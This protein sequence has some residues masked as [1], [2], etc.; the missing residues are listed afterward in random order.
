M[1]INH[2]NALIYGCMGLGGGWNQNP[3]SADDEKTA[4]DAIHKALEIGI[5]TFDHAD[6][7]TFGKA[8]EVFGRV[9]QHN[10][11]LRGSITLQSK[12][13]ISLANKPN[14]ANTYNLSKDYLLGQVHAILK[15]LQTEYL[16]VLLLHRPDVLMDGNEIAEAFRYLKERG[17]VK[18]FGVSNMSVAQMQYIQ[19]YVDNPLV[20]NQ[21]Q[22]SLGH[23]LALDASVSVNTRLV[24][25]DSGTQGL[26]EYCRMHNITIQA[27]GALDKGLYTETPLHELSGNTLET[28]RIVRSLAE[29]YNISPSSIVLAWLLGLPGAVQPIIGTTQP[30]RIQACKDASRV[31]LAREEWYGLWISARGTALP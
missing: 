25:N 30:S 5:T 14:T 26:L 10:P 27:W 13:G 17:L 28:A 9:L 7:Y 19:H 6:I 24:Q 11:T 21:I 15:R 3:I 18:H 31:T 29:K 12:A 20:A 4:T 16:D 22:L 8:E 1:G 23:T 2:N